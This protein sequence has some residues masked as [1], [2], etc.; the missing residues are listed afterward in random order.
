MTMKAENPDLAQT[1]SEWWA[2]TICP[3]TLILIMLGLALVPRR[4]PAQD[5]EPR[6]YSNTPVG[7]NF[8]VLTYGR[9]VG[10]VFV[11]ATLPVEDLEAE[12]NSA[13]VAYVRTTNFSGRPGKIALILPYAWGSADGKVLGQFARFRRSGLSDPRVKVSVN[14]FGAPA[15]KPRE[16]VK[17]RQGTVVGASLQVTF[18]L[19]QYDPNLR[20]NLGTNRW[21]FKPE[22]GVS[23]ALGKWSLEAYGSVSFFTANHNYLRTSTLQQQPIGAVQGHIAYNFRPQLWAAFDAIYFTGGRTRVDGVKRNDLQSNSRY[24]LTISM[25]LAQQHSLKF[26]FTRGLLTRIGSDFTS[27]G[28]AYQFAWGGAQ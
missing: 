10:D 23:R 20:V 8:L 13:G 2:Q 22:L 1:Q 14:F 24:G 26:L 12:I 5:M 16:F 18:P 27:V 4:A 3:V 19:G 28:V 17:Y 9:S 21:S 25:P 11:D 6:S 15:L 7:M